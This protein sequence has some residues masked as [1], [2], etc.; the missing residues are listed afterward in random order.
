M[1]P[2]VV[3]SLRTLADLKNRFDELSARIGGLAAASLNAV[4]RETFERNAKRR[5]D[6]FICLT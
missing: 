1:A 3:A 4:Y 2:D 5:E 6:D